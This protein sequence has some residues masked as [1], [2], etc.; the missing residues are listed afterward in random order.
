MLWWSF[1]RSSQDLKLICGLNTKHFSCCSR[2]LNLITGKE[3][4]GGPVKT[5]WLD[6]S[7]CNGQTQVFAAQPPDKKPF[8]C[9]SSDI[10]LCS[11]YLSRAPTTSFR[12]RDRCQS[13]LKTRANHQRWTIRLLWKRT[14]VWPIAKYCVLTSC[15]SV[16]G[17]MIQT[18]T[19]SFLHCNW[20][21]NFFG[22][23]LTFAL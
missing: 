5:F 6:Q 1:W 14:A 20:K 4:K 18:P 8:L 3:F 21:G 22:L 16:F 9:F 15:P 13:H 7:A 17:Q 19:C 11:S 12:C 10:H 2:D 23:L